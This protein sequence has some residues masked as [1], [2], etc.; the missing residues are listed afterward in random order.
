M[1]GAAGGTVLG[2]NGAKV[3]IPAGA[4]AINTEIKVE[5][6]AAGA[7]PL[8]AGIA[9]VGQ[10]FAFTP[11][12]TT[13]A[14][15]VTITVPFDPAAVPAGANAAI[16]KTDAALS[17]WAV[18]GGA[19]VNGSHM[20]AQVTSFSDAVAGVELRYRPYASGV[21]SQPKRNHRGLRPVNRV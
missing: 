16:Y 2:P 12:G 14:V 6:T 11:H 1:I 10:V 19:T 18:V 7:P 20:T 8:P 4:L 15:P 17:E 13:F 21:F 3:E 9:A 5:L